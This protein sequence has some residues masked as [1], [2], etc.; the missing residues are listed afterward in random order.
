MRLP[1][2]GR[3]PAYNVQFATAAGSGIIAGVAVATTTDAEQLGPM[4]DQLRGRYGRAPAEHLVDGG[5]RNLPDLVRLAEPACG[6]AVYMPV[7]RPRNGSPRD[8][9]LPRRRDKPAVAEWRMRMGTDEAKAIYRERAPTAEGVN[10]Q[11]CNRGL[12][13]VTVRGRAKVKAVVL[14][15][16][17]AHNLLRSAVLRAAR[18][19]AA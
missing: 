3:R 1:D 10:A 19:G 4:V 11:A 2:G 5:Y 17:L 15:F 9:H 7:P 6:T 14:W 13:A 16:I 18:A 8:P 12:R